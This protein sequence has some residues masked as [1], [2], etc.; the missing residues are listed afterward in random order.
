[1]AYNISLSNGEP[2]VTVAD[3]TVDINYT[4]L[5]LVGKNFAGYGQLFAENFVHLLENFSNS[6][7]PLNPL[8]G[9]LWYDSNGK[10]MKVRTQYNT[11]K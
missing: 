10:V 11:W 4:S 9:Q 8:V 5:N 7:E 3:G 6:S 1:M 2:L